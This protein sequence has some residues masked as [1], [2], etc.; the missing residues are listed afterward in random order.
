MRSCCGMLIDV[1][2]RVVTVESETKKRVRELMHVPESTRSHFN[3]TIEL[4]A[5]P[6]TLR[7]T[8][9]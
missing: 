1:V 7:S 5:E 9:N 3:N 2:M 6:C 8:R 4:V